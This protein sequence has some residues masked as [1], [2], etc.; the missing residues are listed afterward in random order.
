MVWSCMGWP[1]DLR[2]IGNPGPPPSTWPPRGRPR[3][4]P[5]R[6]PPARGESVR[7]ALRAP[8]GEGEHEVDVVRGRTGEGLERPPELG[9]RVDAVVEGGGVGVGDAML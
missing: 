3:L 2:H 6:P 4:E 9:G 5:F 8:D 1:I 7:A